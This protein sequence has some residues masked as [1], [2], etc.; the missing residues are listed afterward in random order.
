[1]T[2]QPTTGPRDVHAAVDDCVQQLADDALRRLSAA[3]QLDTATHLRVLRWLDVAHE[4]VGLGLVMSQSRRGRPDPR[5]LAVAIMLAAADGSDAVELERVRVDQLVHSVTRQPIDVR[6]L[7]RALSPSVPDSPATLYDSATPVGADV[8][9]E[10]LGPRPDPEHVVVWSG[11]PGWRPTPEALELLRAAV[12]DD[13]DQAGED[14]AGEQ[15]GDDR[16]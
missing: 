5:S 4:R 15:D 13:E 2:T 9:L 14:Q 7:A 11:V 1:M 12:D 8:L 3:G 16:G 10:H 6:A